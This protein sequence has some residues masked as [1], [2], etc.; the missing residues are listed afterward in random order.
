MSPQPRNLS[1]VDLP[2]GTLLLKA[3]DFSARRHTD[4][5]RKGELMV[6]YVNHPIRVAW[7]L[8]SVGGIESVEILCAALLHDT[9]EDTDTT[10]EELR[11]EF[12]DAITD[13]VLEVTDDKSLPKA[14]RKRRQVLH[15]AEVSDGAAVIKL[16]DKTSNVEDI[17]ESPPANW[18]LQRRIEYLDWT[19]RVVN[20]LTDVNEAL[21]RHYR[22]T[23]AHARETIAREEAASTD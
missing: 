2:A 9:I 13:L 17:A 8:A 18:T 10:E 3:A 7:Y 23:L 12:G 11:R 22:D 19:E 14:E 15:A 5:R 1:S 21:E 16:A 6:P 4:Q 20:E